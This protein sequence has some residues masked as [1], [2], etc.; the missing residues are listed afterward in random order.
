MTLPH[1]PGLHRCDLQRSLLKQAPLFSSLSREK[2]R[3]N[4]LRYDKGEH[5]VKK[6]GIERGLSGSFSPGTQILV[7]SS[8]ANGGRD[9]IMEKVDK[10]R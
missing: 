10:Y 7:V 9:V 4:Q 5:D 6:K 8:T 1:L 2:A 3:F